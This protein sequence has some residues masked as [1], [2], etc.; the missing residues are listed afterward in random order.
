MN[1]KEWLSQTKQF[2]RQI[3]LIKVRQTSYVE[4]RSL[5]AEIA[6]EFTD[7]INQC[8]K[9]IEQRVNSLFDMRRQIEHVIARVMDVNKR[10]TLESYFLNDKSITE[11]AEEKFFSKR[12]IERLLEE[13]MKEV[14]MMLS[15]DAKCNCFFCVAL[16]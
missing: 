6:L 5:L 9:S 12:H 16:N 3:E 8:I 15:N 4:H 11:I 1:I 10:I 7:G 14:E 2:D 13:G